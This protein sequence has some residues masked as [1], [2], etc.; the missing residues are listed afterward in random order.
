MTARLAL[1]LE[2]RAAR[3]RRELLAGLGLG[4][5]RPGAK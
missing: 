3:R 1:T 2:E 4:I 5:V